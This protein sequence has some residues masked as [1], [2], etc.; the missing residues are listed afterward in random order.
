MM[1]G[2]NG[3]G[4]FQPSPYPT[5]QTMMMSQPMMSQP[6]MSQPMMSQPMMGQPMMGQQ[7]GMFPGGQRPPLSN[8]LAIY[9]PPPSQQFMGQQYGQ[10]NEDVH[11]YTHSI[12]NY[13]SCTRLNGVHERNEL[14]T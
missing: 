6:M 5:S 11:T 13:S 9:Q 1:G 3:S 4:N 7:P 2:M 10:V 12:Y 14:Y 8:Q